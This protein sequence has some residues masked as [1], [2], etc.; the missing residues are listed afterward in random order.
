MSQLSRSIKY[1]L[2]LLLSLKEWLKMQKYYSFCLKYGHY[3]D[4]RIDYINHAEEQRFHEC[5]ILVNKIFLLST[6]F[7]YL[8]GTTWHKPCVQILS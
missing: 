8:F 4:Y 6:V 5:K 7:F 2:F 3:Y 1:P